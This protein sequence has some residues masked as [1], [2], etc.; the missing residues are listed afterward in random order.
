MSEFNNSLQVEQSKLWKKVMQDTKEPQ[1]RLE[2]GRKLAAQFL[3]ESAERRATAEKIRPL[4]QAALKAYNEWMDKYINDDVLPSP[5]KAIMDRI[6]RDFYGYIMADKRSVISWVNAVES[7]DEEDK[8]REEEAKKLA[9]YCKKQAEAEDVSIDSVIVMW[10]GFVAGKAY[11]LIPNPEEARKA[12]EAAMEEVQDSED[13][14]VQQE[15]VN[16]QKYIYPAYVQ[17]L[18]KT[19]EYDKVVQKVKEGLLQPALRD[20]WKSREGNELLISYAHAV[21]M[22]ESAGAGDFTDAIEKLGRVIANGELRDGAVAMAEIMAKAKLH[23][24]PRL[25]AEKWLGVA[26]GFYYQGD[27]EFRKFREFRDA[28]ETEKADEQFKIAFDHYQNSIPYFQRAIARARDTRVSLPAD[29][30]KIEPAA[31]VE[32]GSAFHNSGRYLEAVISFDTVRK[33]F[34]PESRTKWLPDPNK[35]AKFYA[36]PAVA[37]A[38]KLLDAKDRSGWLTKAEERMGMALRANAASGRQLVWNQQLLGRLDTREDQSYLLAATKLSEA[39]IVW[40]EAFDHWRK[41]SSPQEKDK[42]GKNFEDAIKKHE[43]SLALFA[44]VPKNTESYEKALFRIGA[45]Y[46][47]ISSLY[48]PERLPQMKPE[49][50]KAKTGEAAE[51]AEKSFKAYEA[52]VEKNQALSD[53]LKEERRRNEG[54]LLAMRNRLAGERNDWPA[55][56]A[57]GKKWYEWSAKNQDLSAG[58]SDARNIK[59]RMIIALLETVETA[60]LA[61]AEQILTQCE[62]IIA[63]VGDDPAYRL[64]SLR[65]LNSR[66]YSLLDRAK[67]AAADAELIGRITNRLVE[68]QRRCLTEGEALGGE[69]MP[70]MTDFRNL[71]AVLFESKKYREAAEMALNI[72]KRFDPENKNRVLGGDDDKQG[73]KLYWNLI[74]DAK[75]KLININNP[76]EESRCLADHRM[77]LDFMFDTTEGDAAREN[78]KTPPDDDKYPRNYDKALEQIRTIRKNYANNPG[79]RTDDPKMGVILSGEDNKDGKPRS[80]LQQIADEAEFRKRIMSTR[81]LFVE[82]AGIAA[83]QLDATDKTAADEFRKGVE[84]QLKIIMEHSDPGPNLWWKM[85]ESAKKR[86]DWR[87]AEKWLIMIKDKAHRESDDYFNASKGLSLIYFQRGAF[88]D[89]ADYALFV[90]NFMRPDSEIVKKL[91]PDVEEFLVKCK[92]GDPKIDITDS[93]VATVAAEAPPETEADRQMQPL[94]PILASIQRGSKDMDTPTFREKYNLCKAW[95]ET[96]RETWRAD[97]L[98][99]NTPKDFRTPKLSERLNVLIELSDLQKELYYLRLMNRLSDRQKADD[100]RKKVA[101]LN[102]KLGK[103][104]SLDDLKKELEEAKKQTQTGPKDPEKAVPANEKNEPE[105]EKNEPTDEQ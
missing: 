80:V 83:S 32:M 47:S 19:Y 4:A 96:S 101:N 102:E 98:F 35:D 77:L 91:W 7:Y 68:T 94:L 37:N 58:A 69:Y 24:M 26:R 78:E 89:A 43:E 45:I 34:D 62:N 48:A 29:R 93:H 44:K 13:K 15:I 72:L 33:T 84:E 105:E 53:R 86:G 18:M 17:M 23:Q 57:L 50:V 90:R 36:Q 2:I 38:I 28:K 63:E 3:K 30:L 61:E 51:N 59:T 8:V 40:K 56:I 60:D 74:S 6:D 67:K 65:N 46:V 25:S 20:L 73:W 49:V 66:W 104:P 52:H 88:A 95:Q 22:R 71:T 81:E 21:T 76:T 99:V 100:L 55:A 11:S 10:Y 16:I 1:K 87:E 103:L 41:A 5:P 82:A 9:E 97:R 12:W 64:R 42:L 39:G 75:Y 31:W 92:Q 54:E 85:V 27:V 70:S 14:A 79:C